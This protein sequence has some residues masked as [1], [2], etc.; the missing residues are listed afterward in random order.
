MKANF[1]MDNCDG[2]LWWKTVAASKKNDRRRGAVA[3]LCL[4]Q[5]TMVPRSHDNLWRGV[6]TR[7]PLS[8]SKII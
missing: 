4:V 1:L 8:I 6:R 7:I 3:E 2:K 5:A